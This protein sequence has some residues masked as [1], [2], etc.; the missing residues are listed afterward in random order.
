MY[1]EITLSGI[2]HRQLSISFST[3]EVNY[4]KCYNTSAENLP[5]SMWEKQGTGIVKEY[6]CG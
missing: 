1:Y 5:V 2:H 3:V 4:Q 6:E